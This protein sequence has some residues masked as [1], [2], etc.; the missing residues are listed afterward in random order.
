MYTRCKIHPIHTTQISHG[1]YGLDEKPSHTSG[2]IDLLFILR[3]FCAR[4]S[5]GPFFLSQRWKTC[6][7]K[8]SK[9]LHSMLRDLKV[10]TWEMNG[11]TDEDLPTTGWRRYHAKI[12]QVCA[13]LPPAISPQTC[14]IPIELPCIDHLSLS[15]SPSLSSSPSDNLSQ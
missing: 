9:R 7:I 1:A 11:S 6:E 3:C 13:T 12:C 10:K 8:S 15:L 4:D 2:T 5:L 14:Y